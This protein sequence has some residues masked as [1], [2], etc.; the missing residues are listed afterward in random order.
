[1]CVCV[2]LYASNWSIWFFF[3]KCQSVTKIEYGRAPLAGAIRASK[4]SEMVSNWLSGFWLAAIFLN[5]G[6]IIITTFFYMVQVMNK[7]S[8]L[9]W[10]VSKAARFFCDS[11]CD[12]AMRTNRHQN[13]QNTCTHTREIMFL[14]AGVHKIRNYGCGCILCHFGILSAS[15]AKTKVCESPFPGT[16]LLIYAYWLTADMYTWEC[17]RNQSAG[18]G[19]ECR[20]KRWS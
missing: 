13:T 3:F 18:K 8:R 17:P 19:A 10:L 6:R 15:D 14:R 5:N 7:I 9:K 16:G 4:S 20:A 12:S 2:W 11:F 1:M